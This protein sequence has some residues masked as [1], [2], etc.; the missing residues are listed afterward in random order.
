M[1]KRFQHIAVLKGGPSAERD[2]SLAS[3]GAIASA[4]RA[5]GYTVEEVDV[6]RPA[7]DLPSG[8]EAVFIALHG[9]FGEDGG[10]QTL[11]ERKGIPFTGSNAAVSR[12]AFDKAASK[13]V[14]ERHGIATA[15]Y[16]VLK[17][18]EPRTLRLPVVVKP[19]RQGSSIG[20]TK[21]FEESAWDAAMET[22]L[23]YD[24]EVLV[25]AFIPGAELTVGVVG[26]QV[27][28]VIEIRAPDGYY[29]YRAKYTKG[30]TEYLVPAPLSADDTRLCQRLAWQ[31]FAALGCRGMGRVDIRMTPEGHAYVLEM[32]TIPGFTE[33]SLL[34][35][36]AR[37]A[38]LEFGELCEMILNL[39]AC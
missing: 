7:L 2:V 14:F 22:A 30:L 36:A 21:V 12:V 39:A 19:L 29:D 35:K 11:L 26:E 25:E 13:R 20:L 9:T 24:P 18:G 15:R 28:P 16:E 17:R 4:L 3:G 38:G 34:P 27:L 10:V 6:T 32:N 1:N 23:A 31:T 5:R 37:A 33:T 8:I